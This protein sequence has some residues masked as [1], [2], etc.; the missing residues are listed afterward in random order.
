VR[1][2]RAIDVDPVDGYAPEAF[3]PNAL[4]HRSGFVAVDAILESEVELG[5]YDVVEAAAEF[6]KD[7]AMLE[8]LRWAMEP[9][10]TMS[11]E[12]RGR[13]HAEIREMR[14]VT[15]DLVQATRKL[16]ELVEACMQEAIA[17]SRVEQE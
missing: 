11:R 10:P 5:K 12:E 8:R 3:S 2:L 7:P 16:H 17:T 9:L 15:E 13:H 4:S 6:I 1:V 14:R